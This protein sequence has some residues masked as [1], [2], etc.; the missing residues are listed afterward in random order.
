M[1]NTKIRVLIE[2]LQSLQSSSEIALDFSS[3]RIDTKEQELR[4][5]VKDNSIDDAA[6]RVLATYFQNVY[7]GRFSREELKIML[8]FDYSHIENTSLYIVESSRFDILEPPTDLEASLVNFTESVRDVNSTHL[9][10]LSINKT[11]SFT[12]FLNYLL[13]QL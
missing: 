12:F 2:K 1:A 5:K 7:L 13:E 4:N 8:S 10:L 11:R 3:P 9:K 6:Y